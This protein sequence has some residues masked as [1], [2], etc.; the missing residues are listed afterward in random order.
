VEHVC[1]WSP[2]VHERGDRRDVVAEPCQPLR[3]G[4]KVD[5]FCIRFDLNPN[6]ANMEKIF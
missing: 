1:L 5:N 3:L 4:M 2:L 6:Y